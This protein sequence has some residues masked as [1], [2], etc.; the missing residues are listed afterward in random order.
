MV[1]YGGVYSKEVFTNSKKFSSEESF[2]KMINDILLQYGKYGR[3]WLQ[4]HL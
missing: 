4:L 3:L 2:Q 1:S